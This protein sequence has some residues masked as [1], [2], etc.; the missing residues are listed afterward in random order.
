MVSEIP[1][2]NLVYCHVMERNW[3]G[4]RYEA[5]TPEKI[6]EKEFRGKFVVFL[7]SESKA[8]IFGLS[9]GSP[10]GCIID[11]FERKFGDKVLDRCHGGGLIS[12]V[13]KTIKVFDESESFGKY[14]KDMVMPL[15]EKY[16]DEN[17]PD[18]KIDID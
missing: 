14:K 11:Y 12:I 5:T 3:K 7:D 6:R 10:H 8:R 18:Y 1:Y 16:R 15:I 2:V 4:D 9:G 13:D 17:L